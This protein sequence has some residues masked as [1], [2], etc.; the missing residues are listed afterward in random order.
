MLC[1][2]CDVK[3]QLIKCAHTG[4]A[5]FTFW[6]SVACFVTFLF[7]SSTVTTLQ[8]AGGKKP[9]AQNVLLWYLAGPLSSPSGLVHI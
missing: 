9:C 3:Q 4:I 1:F 8:R 2:Y 6:L 7:I 5:F